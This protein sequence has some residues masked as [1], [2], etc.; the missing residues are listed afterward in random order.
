MACPEINAGSAAPDPHQLNQGSPTLH[1]QSLPKAIL[2]AAN[3]LSSVCQF[4]YC[5][6]NYHTL[7]FEKKLNNCAKR[8]CGAKMFNISML[9]LGP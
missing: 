3:P 4:R 7:H 6:P 1:W 2:F 5:M 8:H 9:R